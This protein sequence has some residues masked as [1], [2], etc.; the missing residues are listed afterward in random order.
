MAESLPGKD[1]SLWI[2]TTKETDYPTL[3]GTVSCDVAV[4][5]GGITGLL[6][7]WYLQAEGLKPIVL[8]KRRLVSWTTGNTT[9]KLTS[10]HYL[11]YKYLIDNHG[12]ETARAYAQANEDG[13]VGVRKLSEELGIDCDFSQRDA[14]VY[15][16][17]EATADE[18]KEEVEA[19]KTLGLPS[20]FETTTDLPFEVRA[21]IKFSGQAQFHPR[22]F[23]L[24]IAERLAD[25]NVQIFEQTEVTDVKPGS[26]HTLETSQGKVNARYVVIAS[27]FPIWRYE[28]F[29][30]HMWTKMSYALG[31]RLKQD[32]AYPQGM[33]VTTDDPMRTIRSHPYED[34]EI[35]VFGGES[36]KLE[37]DYNADEHYKNLLADVNEKFDVEE[38]VYRWYAG[39]A[40]PYDRM[41]YIGE[42]PDVQGIYA[43]T[44]Y[45][46]WGL[47]WSVSAGRIITDKILG[48]PVEWAEPFNLNRLNA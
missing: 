7:A 28:L 9:A 11:V 20:S 27:Q 2:D 15:T 24:G 10:Q 38:V 35:L 12:V 30:K 26:P 39:D 40:M 22:K 46:A 4:V 19:A 48:R 16:Q 25:N 37:G 3:G 34:G 23:L 43:V 21:A 6:A 45:R 14:F 1:A 31:V 29:D 33:Y 36:H 18:I 13:I 44:G 47:A 32:S 8:D 42:Y 5:G 41:P 17:H